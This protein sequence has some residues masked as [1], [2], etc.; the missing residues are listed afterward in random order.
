[1]HRVAHN[2]EVDAAPPIEPRGADRGGGGVVAQRWRPRRHRRVGLLRSR[3][4]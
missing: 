3:A 4:A 1:L 2:V